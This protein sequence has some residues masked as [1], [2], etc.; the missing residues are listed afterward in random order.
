MWM[1][2]PLRFISGQQLLNVGIGLAI[3]GIVLTLGGWM[4]FQ[5]IKGFDDDKAPP[6][7]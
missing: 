7:G 3:A 1:A 5:L 6:P 4:V 2:Y